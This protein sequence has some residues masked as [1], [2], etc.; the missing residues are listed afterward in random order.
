M[1]GEVAEGKQIKVEG[2]WY[3]L[4]ECC[5]NDPTRVIDDLDAATVPRVL[6]R[7]YNSLSALFSRQLCETCRR[8][9]STYKLGN[10]GRPMCEECI[11][12]CG[13]CG[14]SATDRDSRKLQ[15]G[16]QQR[17]EPG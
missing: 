14:G 8:G 11:D 6:A 3:E 15:G 1:G 13:Y 12:E 5:W 4:G 10:R 2:S 17:R 7:H 16:T 9:P